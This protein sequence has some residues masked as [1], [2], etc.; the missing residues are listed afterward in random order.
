[1]VVRMQHQVFK[2]LYRSVATGKE[3]ARVLKVCGGKNYQKRLKKELD[4]IGNSEMW[5][6]GAA[7][8]SLRPKESAKKI[9]KG[10]KGVGGR[11]AN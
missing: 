6:A 10:T 2:R 4:A 1:M 9:T 5:R 11:K 8:R 3:T 7:T